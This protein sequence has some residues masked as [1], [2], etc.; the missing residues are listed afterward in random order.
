MT[1]DDRA[2]KEIAPGITVDPAVHFGR[3]VVKGTRV[4]I[5]TILGQ[6]AA[7]LTVERVAEEY[8]VTREAVLAVLR[9]AAELVASEEVRAT[10]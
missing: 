7:G 3:P 5:E 1:T 10:G 9:Y 8:G 2:T 4:P 6:L